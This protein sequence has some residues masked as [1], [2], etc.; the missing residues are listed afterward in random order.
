METNQ[1]NNIK[2]YI[3]L[4]DQFLELA[5]QLS[6]WL[7]KLGEPNNV[8]NYPMARPIMVPNPSR[9]FLFVYKKF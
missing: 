4:A 6:L 8:S 2:T 7:K 5:V 1:T 3:G 9:F